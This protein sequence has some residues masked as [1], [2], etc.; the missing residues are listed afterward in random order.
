MKDIYERLKRLGKIWEGKFD[1]LDKLL[2]NIQ[3]LKN[4]ETESDI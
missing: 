2:M 3:K 4:N 1:Q